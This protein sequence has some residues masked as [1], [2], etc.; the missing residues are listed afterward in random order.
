M[1]NKVS[2]DEVGTLGLVAEPDRRGFATDGWSR[3]HNVR[4]HNGSIKATAAGTCVFQLPTAEG[5]TQYTQFTYMAGTVPYWVAFGDK[6]TYAI[7]PASSGCEMFTVDGN[8]HVIDTRDA[9]YPTHT[10]IV[11]KLYGNLIGTCGVGSPYYIAPTDTFGDPLG[12]LEDWGVGGYYEN[13]TCDFILAHHGHIIAM[14]INNPDWTGDNPSSIAWSESLQ[15]VGAVGGELPKYWGPTPENNAGFFWL[16]ADVGTIL[17]AK[18][19][20]DDIII[21]TE[22][23]VYR[24]AWVGGNAVYD[25]R[26]VFANEGIFGPRCVQEYNGTHFVVGKDDIYMFDGQAM[27]SVADGKVRR[28]IFDS[29]TTDMQNRVF[30]TI[31]RTESEV[32]VCYPSSKSVTGV[33]KAYIFSLEDG[34]WS[35]RELES[36]A[37]RPGADPEPPTYS[38]L[39]AENLAL[40]QTQLFDPVGISSLT[41]NE[42]E[43]DPEYA[44]MTWDNIAQGETWGRTIGSLGDTDLFELAYL[45]GGVG[46]N[47]QHAVETLNATAFYTL[48]EQDSINYYEYFVDALGK[49]RNLGMPSA[50]NSVDFEE[51]PLMP[52]ST[53]SFLNS[54]RDNYRYSDPEKSGGLVVYAGM[55]TETVCAFMKTRSAGASGLI[56]DLDSVGCAYYSSLTVS[57]F[58]SRSTGE[59]FVTDSDSGVATSLGIGTT[60]LPDTEFFL[61]IQ[62]EPTQVTLTI[63]DADNLTG[64]SATHSFA[65]AGEARRTM[66]AYAYA[67]D[68][69]YDNYAA[70]AGWIDE[71]ACFDTKLSGTDLT[72]LYNA[73]EDV[74]ED[75]KFA[76]LK[77]NMTYTRTATN[78]Y[79]FGETR[80]TA[81]KKFMQLSDD[82]S[83]SVVLRIYPRV[84]ANQ[85]FDVYVGSHD[86]TEKEVSWTG[87]YTF[88]PE[89]DHKIECRCRGRFHAIRFEA[90]G[91]PFL[92]NGFDIEFQPSGRH[93]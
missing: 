16:P 68:Q 44:K 66:L 35:Q 85:P 19:L 80:M 69:T 6:A 5:N 36:V 51:P 24:M 25:F 64:V 33:D 83:T 61:A 50:E 87:P 59:I 74:T 92:L 86:S 15:D 7:K 42:L 84:D 14:N 56:F 78:G 65:D 1:M 63:H 10:H 54:W 58:R 20:R 21:Y 89:T 45:A 52:S 12:V 38:S 27:Q 55:G 88:D 47:Y 60:I 18:V 73:S 91:S 32:W 70:F 23:S 77:T 48:D 72:T 28:L 46:S 31:D 4:I 75:P 67:S 13:S 29:L 30:V 41:W 11:D 93:L 76:V 22:K 53:Y 57:F 82:Q 90:D 62:P 49:Q 43:A 40:Q 71:V 37:T 26:E 8:T 34:G 39:I 17:A 81:E 9:A 3:L 2:I 79:V